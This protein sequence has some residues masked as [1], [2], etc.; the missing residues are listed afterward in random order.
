MTITQ[1]FGRDYAKLWIISVRKF[2]CLSPLFQKIHINTVFAGKIISLLSRFPC[3]NMTAI[4]PVQHLSSNQHSIHPSNLS[5]KS[6]P[7]LA[8]T[9]CLATTLLWNFWTLSL[10][11]NFGSIANK[12]LVNGQ[13]LLG[14]SWVWIDASPADW[15]LINFIAWNS[16]H[17]GHQC[18]IY[19]P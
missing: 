2:A 12:L 6:V 1:P 13:S 16:P 4:L 9:V 10:S 3:F 14:N 15:F 18:S 17:K 8:T 11:H 5:R 7:F 19:S